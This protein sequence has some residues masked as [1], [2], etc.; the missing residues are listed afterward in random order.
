MAS[1]IFSI[2]LVS[3]ASRY[4]A[5]PTGESKW[6]STMHL[7][8]EIVRPA[9]HCPR[10][11]SLLVAFLVLTGPNGAPSCWWPSLAPSDCAEYNGVCVLLAQRAMWRDIRFTGTRRPLVRQPHHLFEIRSTSFRFAWTRACCT[12][13]RRGLPNSVASAT[14]GTSPAG[15]TVPSI[16]RRLYASYAT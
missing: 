6:C 14:L 13:R 7:A 3:S 10:A 5:L 11:T 9:P 16:S 2:A 1:T 8:H 12:R 4:Q 15:K